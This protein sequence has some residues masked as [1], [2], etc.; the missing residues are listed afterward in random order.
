[1]CQIRKIKQKQNKQKQQQQKPQK[2]F[3]KTKTKTTKKH[4]RETHS[5]F[6]NDFLLVFYLVSRQKLSTIHLR[7]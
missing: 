5:I 6:P 1:M 2:K 4:K 7:Y 3:T